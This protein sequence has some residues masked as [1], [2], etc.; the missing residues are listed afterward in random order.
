[1]SKSLI[2]HIGDL[3][4]NKTSSEIARNLDLTIRQEIE[5]IVN[6]SIKE[7]NISANN[8]FLLFSGDLVHKNG[9]SCQEDPQSLYVEAYK[10]LCNLIPD[11]P[12][13]NICLTQGNHCYEQNPDW[14]SYIK[15]NN[16][17]TYTEAAEKILTPNK[18]KKRLPFFELY[19]N[20]IKSGFV[21]NDYVLYDDAKEEYYLY[22]LRQFDKQ[23][24]NIIH[25]N[26]AWL[27]HKTSKDSGK[28]RLGKAFVDHVLTNL[29]QY[30][31][32]L[33]IILSH[34]PFYNLCLDESFHPNGNYQKIFRHASIICNG[35]THPSVPLRD[36]H[37]HKVISHP[38][39]FTN[40]ASYDT[41]REV[42]GHKEHNGKIEFKSRFFR[43]YFYHYVFD[44]ENQTL[45]STNHKINLDRNKNKFNSFSNKEEADLKGSVH[46]E[47]QFDP[48]NQYIRKIDYTHWFK[49]AIDYYKEKCSYN[50]LDGEIQVIDWE[51]IFECYH[52]QIK[53][54]EKK[55]DDT[56]DA[57]ELIIEEINID[58][59]NEITDKT[60]LV[61]VDTKYAISTIDY[62]NVMDHLLRYIV[63]LRAN[64][65]D[66]KILFFDI[67]HLQII[68]DEMNDFYKNVMR[69]KTEA[70]LEGIQTKSSKSLFYQGI[71]VHFYPI[72]QYELSLNSK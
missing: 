39:I 64:K 48:N 68:S 21:D 35:H 72:S 38:K 26:S 65:R 62:W 34:H 42:Y 69:E 11:I 13:K 32:Y 6:E 66:I 36:Q 47:P 54:R 8:T 5:K 7:H 17:N 15:C 16:I 53:K 40:G 50:D 57:D 58:W 71:K 41:M 1:M 56:S 27:C 44:S 4:W 3:H 22:G 30:E 59:S 70:V 9:L 25:L 29:K 12:R 67:Y 45:T 60:R 37:L 31:G 33:T 20:V 24:I 23:K 18:I 10:Y 46:I 55:I 63:R 28:L 51:A 2:F 49:K 52:R 19:N 43:T 61:L 14:T